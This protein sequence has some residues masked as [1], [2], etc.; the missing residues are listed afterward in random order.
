MK[1]SVQVKAGAKENKVEDMGGG[2]YRVRVKA[3]PIEGKANEALVAVLA[4][5]FDVPKRNVR[6]C[7]GRTSKQKMFEIGL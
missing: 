2:H 1:I 5:Y 7:S 3:P 6:L 4:E